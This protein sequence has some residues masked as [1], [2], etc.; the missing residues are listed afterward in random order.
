MRQ[1][2]L[3]LRSSLLLAFFLCGC[4]VGPNYHRPDV[5]TAP[6]WKEQPPWRAADP[7]DSIPKGNWWTTF[8]DS[9][10]DQYET[11]ALKSNQTIEVARYQLEQARASARITQSG[12]FP[13]LNAGIAVQRARNSAGKPTATGIPLTS[14][15][16]SNDFLIPFNLTW[17]ADLF[18]G[19]RRSVESANAT[20]QAS[21]AALENVRLVIT[22]ELAV[23]YFSLR[24]LDAEI[25]VLNSSVEYQN[26]SLT[27]VQ[28]R[29]AG[30]IA[31]GLDVAQQETLL[32]ST[33]TQATLLRQQRA[34]FE[35]ALAALVGVPASTFSVPVK[36]LTLAPPAVPIG[37]PSDVLE[38]RPDIAQSERQMAAQNAQIGVAK[39]AYY[40]GINLSATGGFEDT[41]LGSIIGASTGFWALGA[42]V[43]QTVL[44]GGKRRAQ[45]DFA[46]SGYGASVATYRQTVLTAFQE[47]EDSLSGLSVLAEAAETQQQAVNAAQRALQISNDR[48][49][50]GLVTYL[51]VISAEENFLDAQR[52]ATQ[53]LGQRLVTSVSL[54]KA[55][56]GGWDSSSL[57]AIRVKATVK[58]AIEP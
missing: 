3:R 16:T 4:A 58:Q 35:H 33:R 20:Y 37:V 38:R 12:L 42:N 17:E 48:Y 34:Q 5:A 49:T 7:K 36:P 54:V 25:A 26:K 57:Q 27:L 31:S 13:Q 52:L 24:E 44:S 14:A 23:D 46:K 32:N 15:T 53:I 39:S 41:A 22:S 2:F 10:L 18:G 6:A 51:D 56:G 28:N 11:Q 8:A 30:G 21:A 1:I 9:E 55:L 43:A 29:H 47:V 19:V 50:G 40:P 45:V